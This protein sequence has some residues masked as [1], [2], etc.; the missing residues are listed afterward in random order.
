MG[1]TS[2]P[3]VVGLTNRQRILF[4]TGVIAL[5][6]LLAL[7]IVVLIAP[8]VTQATAV[9]APKT[10]SDLATLLF[11]AASI[12]LI[13]LS[14]VLSL[15][16]IVGWSHIRQSIREDVEKASSEANRDLKEES[17]KVNKQV[18]DEAVKDIQDLK[19]DIGRLDA[20][21]RGRNL[22]LFGYM[23]G[24]MALKPDKPELDHDKAEL[25]RDAV[26]T[27]QSAFDLL[28]RTGGPA[29]F[30]ALNN[31]VFHASIYASTNPEALP[32]RRLQSK[33]WLLAK[34]QILLKAVN[35]HREGG[36]E[37]IPLLLT[38]CCAT[39][40]FNRVA[41]DLRQ[42]LAIAEEVSDRDDASLAQKG[43]AQYYRTSLL[44]T[45]KTLESTTT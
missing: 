33:T 15:L 14:L 22:T 30:L 4:S 16:G 25:L 13:I 42:A 44:E 19:E 39:S 36:P 8:T 17:A 10:F 12:A 1:N 9:D 2:V 5:I 7:V 35:E 27:C 40:L 18:R 38:Y 6:W 20:E 23:L 24:K 32:G 41:T 21:M 34:A 28:E 45:L 26:D 43:E 37:S 29:E 11:G 31:L 3:P